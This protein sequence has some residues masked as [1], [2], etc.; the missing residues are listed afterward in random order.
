M[1]QYVNVIGVGP[2]GFPD[3]M[4]KEQ[5]TEVLK[6]MPPPA[7]A[8]TQAPDTLGRQIGLATRPMAQAALTAGGMLP[9]VVD[10]LV[11]LFN[12]AAGTNIPTQTQAVE[13]TLTGVGFPT[14]RTAQERVIQDVATAGYGTGA[15]T[16]AASEIAPRLPGMASDVA[17][18]FAQSPQAQSA[19]AL[20][21]ASAGGMLR[22]GGAPPALQVGGAMLAGMVA[23]GGPKLTPTQKI[24][25]APGALV[26]PF[27]QTGR[28]VIVGNV[29]NRL[30][31][32]PERAALNLQQAQPL[33]PGVRVTTAAGARDPGLAAAETAIRALDQSGAFP[34]VLSANQQALLESFRRLGGR[35]GDQFTPGSIPYAEAK[36]ASVTGPMRE[37]AF[38]N[39]Q[40]VSV[41]PI[42][43]AISGIMSNPAT[44]RQ[45]VD[46]AMQYVSKL[47][48]K[49]VDKETGTIDPMAL[50]S[51]RKD[52]TDAMAGKLSGDLSNL[53]LARGQMAE[54]L[55]VIDNVIESGAPGFQK[56]MQQFEKSSSA[57]DQM[58]LLQGIEAKVTTGQPNLMTQE[59]V[60]AAGAL[61]RQVA[62]KAEEI[63]AQLSPA[64]QRR[65]D[66]IID[67]INRGQA[68]TAPGVK[69]PGSNTFQN[70]SMGNLIGR[71]FSESM[72]DNTT[73]RTMTRPLDFLYKLP[74]QQIQQLLVEA[75]LDPK[76]A[77]MMM[78]KAN[79]MK[80]EPLAKSLRKKAEEL[81]FGT[82]IGAQE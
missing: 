19:A 68:A 23:P 71:V 20:T 7:A 65:L 42:A 70:M 43:D 63:G 21:A 6:T 24:L 67:E 26:K 72:A 82:A 40:P 44:Q 36:R 2:V 55:P 12:L 27:T 54:L 13:K 34:S 1:T 5:I 81:G 14:P 11:N 22:E 10:P 31:T 76:L 41:A 33:V 56:Y 60:L 35:A 73:L 66:N 52:I 28:E 4:T 58:R 38:A 62:T 59:P 51:V 9:M 69:A 30:A 16:R 46:E 53:R 39:K 80:V 8:P 74:D 78:S 45:T 32:D 29:L 57:I 61:R 48:A 3:D 18:F 15:V 17:K 25:E 47:L 79:V 64:A 50:Y 49:R 75:M 77:A 37:S